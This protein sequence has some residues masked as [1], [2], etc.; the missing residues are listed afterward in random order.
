MLRRLSSGLLQHRQGKIERE[1]LGRRAA[2]H[3]ARQVACAAAEIEHPMSG[4][5]GRQQ[6]QQG[7]CHGA[8]QTGMS[9]VVAGLPRESTRHAL[10]QA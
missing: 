6:G 8:L 5:Q 2:L 1:N 7:I 9:I 4:C 10:A 3:R